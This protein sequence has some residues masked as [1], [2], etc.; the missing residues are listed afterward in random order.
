MERFIHFVQSQNIQLWRVRL[1]SLSMDLSACISIISKT[2]AVPFSTDS[3]DT[4]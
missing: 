3:S 4:V 2:F 1:G